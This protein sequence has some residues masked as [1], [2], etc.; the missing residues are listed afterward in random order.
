[1]NIGTLEQVF[2]FNYQY[3]LR[4]LLKFNLDKAIAVNK[5]KDIISSAPLSLKDK[6]DFGM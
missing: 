2:D 1:M 5:L 3:K 4:M 6:K